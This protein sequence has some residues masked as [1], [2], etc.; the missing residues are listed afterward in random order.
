ME[1]KQEKSMLR[2]LELRFEWY[3]ERG[4]KKVIP[5]NR[6][7]IFIPRVLTCFR[8]PYSLFFYITEF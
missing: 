8:L 7:N 3:E 4:K 2:I 1:M 5:S 6:I